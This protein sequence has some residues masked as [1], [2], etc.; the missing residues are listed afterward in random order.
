MGMYKTES[1]DARVIGGKLACARKG[2]AFCKGQLVGAAAKF[3]TALAGSGL[4]E[5][6]NIQDVV[7]DDTDDDADAGDDADD[8]G[9]YEDVGDDAANND[10]AN[11]NPP[12]AIKV[13]GETIPRTNL[14]L[15]K[16]PAEVSQ[17]ALDGRNG[18]SACSV[19]ALIFAH[20]VWH[21]RLDLPPMLLLCP[22]WV[23]L[24]CTAIRIGNRLYDRC[25]Q[26]LPRRFFV[27]IRGCH[28]CG[29]IC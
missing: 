24:L 12:T 8:D 5:S 27:S 21:Q 28:H 10:S 4:E 18:S 7:E 19:I 11:I 16:C 22:L 23:T 20:G 9:E 17:S 15:W 25:R 29:A 3:E 14:L 13:T 26:S 6:L 1:E 2:I